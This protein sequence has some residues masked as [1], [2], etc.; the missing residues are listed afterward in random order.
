MWKRYFIIKKT[1]KTSQYI[2]SEWIK[3]LITIEF[4]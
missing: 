2:T 1:E 4:H 3:Y